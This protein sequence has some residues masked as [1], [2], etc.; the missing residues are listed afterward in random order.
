MSK[1]SKQLEAGQKF[2]RLT[3]VKLHHIQIYISPKGIKYNIEYYLCKCDCGNE[4]IVMKKCLLRNNVKSCGCLF[5]EKNNTTHGLTNTRFYH[6]WNSIKQRCY[7]KNNKDYKNYGIRGIIVCSEWKDNFKNFYD[8]SIDNGYQD[9][10]E[11][12]RIDNN[13]NYEP[14]NCRWVDIK[15]Q[16]RNRRTN[17]LITYRG[18][19]HCLIEWAEIY[20]ISHTLIRDRLKLGWKIENIFNQN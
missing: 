14:S 7:N 9:T 3:V 8:W 5:K 11:I 20:K 12:D 6:I 17:H 10:L 15:T 18:K 16:A 13:G 4:T 19:T 2:N 1:K